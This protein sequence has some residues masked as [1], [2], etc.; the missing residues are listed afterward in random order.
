MVMTAH[1]ELQPLTGSRG[2]LSPSVAALLCDSLCIAS[3]CVSWVRLRL[4][5]RDKGNVGYAIVYDE[6]RCVLNMS[7][8]VI[9]SVQLPIRGLVVIFFHVL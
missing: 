7:L 5:S 6:S 2:L 9:M 3:N 4:L 1:F 8:P